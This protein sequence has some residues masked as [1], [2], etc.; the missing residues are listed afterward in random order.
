MPLAENM[1]RHENEGEK[2][3]KLIFI[4][5][6]FF[7]SCSSTKTI[8]INS[9][10]VLVKN[11]KVDWAITHQDSIIDFR[12]EGNRYAEIFGDKLIYRDGNDSIKTYQI[13]ELR[14]IHTFREAPISI[15]IFSSLI[16][17]IAIIVSLISGM[18]IG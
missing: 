7:T 10:T 3:K 13:N 15:I 5:I 9:E 6:V 1:K 18:E 14:T 2:L 11:E 16:V 12:K 17:S 4:S 8:S